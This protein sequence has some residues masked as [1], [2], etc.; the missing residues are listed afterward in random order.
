MKTRQAFLEKEAR[1]IAKE[2]ARKY[3]PEKIILFG[4]VARGD[5][6]KDSDIDML[7]VK[8]SKK[9]MPERI[10]EVR[11]LVDADE[12]FDPIVYPLETIEWRVEQGDFFLKDALKEGKVLYDEK[13][14]VS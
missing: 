11:R 4:S 6:D 14:A 10:L 12:P 5:A 2:L 1:R 13:A 9:P 7:I 8:N 3:K